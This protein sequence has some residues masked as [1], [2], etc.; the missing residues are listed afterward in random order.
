MQ[1]N[2]AH[3]IPYVVEKCLVKNSKQSF[4]AF[5]TRIAYVPR[6]YTK[7]TLKSTKSR[8]TWYECIHQDR[9]FYRGRTKRRILSQWQKGP[10][11]E[12]EAIIF[13]KRNRT[14]SLGYSRTMSGREIGIATNHLRRDAAYRRPVVVPS[15]CGVASMLTRL[16]RGSD[17]ESSL[18]AERLI[19]SAQY[20]YG[21]SSDNAIISSEMWMG[22]IYSRYN[23]I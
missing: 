2:Q 13:K 17:R 22:R 1:A 11:L 20:E 9:I 6:R 12:A 7:C 3:Q 23:R 14:N 19:S 18:L 15:Y 21:R 5:S 4:F 10:S 16:Y 8:Q